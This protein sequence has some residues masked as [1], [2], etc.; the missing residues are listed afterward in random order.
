MAEPNTD[1]PESTKDPQGTFPET[2]WSLLLDAVEEDPA[3]LA[4]LCQAYWYPIYAF[5]RRAGSSIEDS[6]DL[7]QGFF[8]KMVGTDFLARARKDRGRLRSFILHC[9]QNFMRDEWQKG[10]AAKRGGGKQ[11][12][13]I[14][15]VSA[16]ARLA[17]EPLEDVTPELEYER[18]WAREM[19]RQT[20][21][22]LKQSYT[23]AGKAE[24]FAHLQDHLDADGSG[25]P[26][27]E[28]A[29][30]LGVKEAQARFLVF[31]LRQRY[32]EFLRKAVNETVLSSKDAE[33]E[34]AHLR[35]VFQTPGEAI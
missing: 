27:P 4:E 8:A 24:E 10:Q 30:E 17:L 1:L 13:S 16:E 33:E 5:A 3:A 22:T 29:V 11:P 14:D 31:K 18:S 35:K 26:Y 6:E 15:S 32:A 19:L 20:R 21:E 2:R 34:L 12:L 23:E 7:T 25:K 9:F 28:I